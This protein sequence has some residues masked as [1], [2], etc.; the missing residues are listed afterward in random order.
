[1]ICNTR[2]S[3]ELWMG[4]IDNWLISM[5]D[6]LYLDRLLFKLRHDALFTLNVIFKLKLFQFLVSIFIIHCYTILVCKYI[7]RNRIKQYAEHNRR[8]WMCC[9]SEISMVVLKPVLF[10]WLLTSVDLF[11]FFL[12]Y[13]EKKKD[14]SCKK[15]NWKEQ[16]YSSMCVRFMHVETPESI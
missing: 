10:S 3:K 1:V 6:T 11:S 9:S 8:S 12:Q 7:A 14:E 5:L 15:F 13:E 2:S 4:E 16:A